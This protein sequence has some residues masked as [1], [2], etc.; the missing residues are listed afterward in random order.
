M[1]AEFMIGKR[2]IFSPG[3]P[4]LEAS[5]LTVFLRKEKSSEKS[6]IDMAVSLA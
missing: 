2:H 1:V 5:R 4:P 6:T 3:I